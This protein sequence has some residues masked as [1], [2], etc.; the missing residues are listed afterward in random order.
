MKAIY[1]KRRYKN[2]ATIV[3]YDASIGAICSEKGSEQ[4]W[5][6]GIKVMD[7]SWD[8]QYTDK[9]EEVKPTTGFRR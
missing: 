5:F 3:K 9:T 2:E 6:L 8:N 7:N 1:T 4:R